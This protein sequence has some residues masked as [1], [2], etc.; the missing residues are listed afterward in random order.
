MF[1][2]EDKWKWLLGCKVLYF[3]PSS[4][5]ELT[6]LHDLQVVS[7]DLSADWRLVLNTNYLQGVNAKIKRLSN[8]VLIR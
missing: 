7:I 5:H 1:G 3:T 2:C 8:G 4:K 6:D